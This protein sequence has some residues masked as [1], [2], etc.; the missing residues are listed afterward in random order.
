VVHFE[1]QLLELGS[2]LLQLVVA[3]ALEF[4]DALLESEDECTQLVL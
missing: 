3:P 1:A 2:Q 4:G